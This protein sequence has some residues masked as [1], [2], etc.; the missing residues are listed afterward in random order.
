MARSGEGV[1]EELQDINRESHNSTRGR[2]SGNHEMHE[3]ALEIHSTPEVIHVDLEVG[4]TSW[5]EERENQPNKDEK[6]VCMILM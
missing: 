5:E 4:M 3:N 2:S 6:G 1:E